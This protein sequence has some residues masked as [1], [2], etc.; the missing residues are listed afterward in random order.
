METSK[1]VQALSA[2]VPR[3]RAQWSRDVAW[4]RRFTTHSARSKGG[5]GSPPGSLYNTSAKGAEAMDS[6]LLLCPSITNTDRYP[7]QHGM[8]EQESPAE[9]IHVSTIRPGLH[10][11]RTGG[12]PG[13]RG[14]GRRSDRI[15]HAP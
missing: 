10:R 11:H 2:A 4:P 12:E 15:R 3:T 8:R 14:R 7:C 1:P 13:R 9:F 6:A 5:A